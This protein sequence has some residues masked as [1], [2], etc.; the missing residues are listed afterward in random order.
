MEVVG[1]TL[2]ATINDGGITVDN[3]ILS[4]NN[5][6]ASASNNLTLNA[7]SGETI[8]FNI[9]NETYSSLSSSSFSISGGFNLI[10]WNNYYEGRNNGNT[11]IFYM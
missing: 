11:E 1:S 6:T 3:G 4:S 8:N 2:Y 10:P 9:N 7:P 5:I